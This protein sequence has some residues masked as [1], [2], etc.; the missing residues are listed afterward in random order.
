L[1]ACFEERQKEPWFLVTDLEDLED[2]A[3]QVMAHY[4]RR[5]EI[6]ELFKDTKN[7]K[8]G[9]CFRGL[10]LSNA[11]RYDRLFLV[12]CF[13][14]FFLV[15]AGKRA[16]AQSFHRRLMANTEKRKRT[17]SLWRVGWYFLR[18]VEVAVRSI[19]VETRGLAYSGG[20]WG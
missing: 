17:L 15:L 19:L 16:E 20:N 11:Q 2:P 4:G 7:E 8:L 13:A 5:M 9:F 3:R 1:V 18:S 12:L 6:E 14:Y 10:R